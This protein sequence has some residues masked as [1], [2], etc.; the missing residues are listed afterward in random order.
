MN[1]NSHLSGYLAGPEV[2]DTG[3]HWSGILERKVVMGSVLIRLRLLQR[4]KLGHCQ[5]VENTFRGSV[6]SSLSSSKRTRVRNLQYYG[7]SYLEGRLA[8]IE[9]DDDHGVNN[10][11]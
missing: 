9:I 4:T 5:L 2:T 10:C 8:E 11:M 7:S 1:T 3:G 6:A